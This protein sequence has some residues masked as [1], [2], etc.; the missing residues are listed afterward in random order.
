MADEE[1]ST[2]GMVSGL[3]QDFITQLRAVTEGWKAWPDSVSAACRPLVGF[4][5]LAPYRRRS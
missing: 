5:C 2:P 3:V 4:R 1:R